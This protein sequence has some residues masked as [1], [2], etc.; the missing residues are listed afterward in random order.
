MRDRESTK[1]LSNG[2]VRYGIYD[3]T[4]ALLRYEYIKLEDEP[5]VAGSIYNRANVLPDP[6]CEALGIPNTAEPKD[7]FLA[8]MRYTLRRGKAS[9]FERYMMGGMT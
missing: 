9:T 7:A 5:T 1:I 3:E 8:G 2:A 4:G 6:V